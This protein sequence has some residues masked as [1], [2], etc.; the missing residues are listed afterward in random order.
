MEGVLHYSSIS[1]DP[2]VASGR[3][4]SSVRRVLRPA[5]GSS[6]LVVA[7]ESMDGWMDAI[8]YGSRHLL[9]RSRVFAGRATAGAGGG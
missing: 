4:V 6:L 8:V 1:S 9:P 2:P 7:V 3:R 5:T